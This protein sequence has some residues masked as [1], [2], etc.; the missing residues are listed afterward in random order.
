MQLV[1]GALTCVDQAQFEEAMQHGACNSVLLKVPSTCKFSYRTRSYAATLQLNQV[2]TISEFI[3]RAKMARKGGWSVVVGTTLG[4]TG[5]PFIGN[6]C[7][8]LGNGQV[9]KRN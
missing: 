6:L 9:M 2:A 4:E 3:H 7:I 5:D 1:G 8:G